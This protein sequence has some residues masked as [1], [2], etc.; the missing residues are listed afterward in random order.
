MN[1]NA[2]VKAVALKDIR[3]KEQLY[4]VIEV[5]RTEMKKDATGKE[6]QTKVPHKVA[7][8][9]GQKTYDGVNAMLT[10]EQPTLTNVSTDEKT[11][12]K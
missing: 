5:E 6:V 3:D 12:L 8:N 2:Q 4:I 9:V 11:F 1:N 7:I 10:T